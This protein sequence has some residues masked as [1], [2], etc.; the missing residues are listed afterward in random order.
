MIN[1]KNHG[2]TLIELLI[3][4]AIIGILISI[5]AFAVNQAQ[6]SARNNRRK[7]DLE[8]IRAGLEMYRSDCGQYPAAASNQVPDPLIGSGATTNCAS[9]N[10]YLSQVPNDPQS[11]SGKYYLYA[12]LTTTSYELCAYQEGFSAA[13]AV[14]CGGSQNCGAG[15]NSCVA[16]TINDAQCLL[17]QVNFDGCKH[18]AMNAAQVTKA[19]CLATKLDVYNNTTTC[20]NSGSC[21]ASSC[22]APTPTPTP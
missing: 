18:D 13:E 15:A 17:D 7:A 2:F 12:Q 11:P 3:T 4:I 5:S 16:D 19:N 20:T 9:A 6:Q 14:T 21:G 8:T 1:T 10:V 22:P